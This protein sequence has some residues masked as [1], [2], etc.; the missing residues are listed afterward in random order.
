MTFMSLVLSAY[1]TEMGLAEY[2]I[3]NTIRSVSGMSV[4]VYDSGRIVFR[5]G[6][7]PMNDGASYQMYFSSDSEHIA[8]LSD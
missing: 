4:D 3:L 2:P 8:S 1:G 5:P 6:S 7:R